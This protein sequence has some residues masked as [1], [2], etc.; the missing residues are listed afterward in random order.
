MEGYHV[1]EECKE[2]C[3]KL[4]SSEITLEQ[5]LDFAKKKAGVA[6]S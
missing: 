3:R 2:W 6:V 1:D 5:Y 4:L